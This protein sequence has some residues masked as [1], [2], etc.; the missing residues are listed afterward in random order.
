[1]KTTEVRAL[2]REVLESIAKPY[3]HHVIDE[4]FYAI[5][6]KPQWHREYESLCATLGKTVVNTWGGYW[7]ANTLGKVGE[8]QVPSKKSKLIGSYSILDTDAKTIMR[9][10]KEADALQLMAAYYQAHKAE[11]PPEIRKHRELILEL[12]MEGMAPEAA[13]AMVL[14]NGAC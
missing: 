3:S 2:V 9:K 5:E 1:M 8:Q 11:L 7:I 14:K 4:V 13:F 10:P 6:H 12:L